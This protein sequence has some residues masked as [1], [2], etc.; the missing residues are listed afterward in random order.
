M[1]IWDFQSFRFLSIANFVLLL[2]AF[3]TFVFLKINFFLNFF[4]TLS[5]VFLLHSSLLIFYLLFILCLQ[6]FPIL[7]FFHEFYYLDLSRPASFSMNSLSF[8]SFL[9]FLFQRKIYYSRLDLYSV[10]LFR[11]PF[12][13]YRPDLVERSKSVRHFRQNRR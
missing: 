12:L 13:H 9:P 5:R 8:P 2:Y 7:A 4:P 6:L 10:L 3:H 11:L 1:V